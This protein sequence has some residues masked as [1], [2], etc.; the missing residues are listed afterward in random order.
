MS[1]LKVAAAQPG[2]VKPKMCIISAY[3]DGLVPY[4]RS[5]LSK[6][7]LRPSNLHLRDWQVRNMLRGVPFLFGGGEMRGAEL[8]GTH[9]LLFCVL[10]YFILLILSFLCSFCVCFMCFLYSL[11]LLVYFFFVLFVFLRLW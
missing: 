5:E 2:F 6:D 7:C 8:G 1:L 4:E 10:L 11:V 9:I 3:P